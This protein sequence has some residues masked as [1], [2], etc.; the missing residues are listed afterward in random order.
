MPE[1]TLVRHGQA[2]QNATSVTLRRVSFGQADV[3]GSATCK[4]NNH[5]A[6]FV[7]FVVSGM[8][9][10]HNRPTKK[11]RIQRGRGAAN[12]ISCLLASCLCKLLLVLAVARLLPRRIL[13]TAKRQNT[14]A[15]GAR[16][17]ERNV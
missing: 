7:S 3:I 4:R 12:R 17:E 5:D 10:A 2:K 1:I 13:C 11:K 16:F 14:H 9:V 8:L 6:V 15:L